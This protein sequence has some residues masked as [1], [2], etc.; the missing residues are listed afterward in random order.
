VDVKRH[1][2]IT[3]LPGVGKTTMIRDIAD[4]LPGKKSGFF[5]RE[6]RSGGRRTG[7]IIETLDG[8]EAILAR[9]TS[10]GAH[11]V[12]A[13]QV[14]VENLERLALPAIQAKA[15]IIIIDEIG[16]MECLSEKF[17]RAVLNI[18]DGDAR[19]VAT[20]AKKGVGFIKEVKNR[21][22][23]SLFEVTPKNRD[24]VA[25]MLRRRLLDSHRKA[26]K[27]DPNDTR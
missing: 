14:F 19:V 27:D 15:D 13:Y 10:A 23:V 21:P 17:K 12:G 2:L 9:K 7:F 4:A 8:G 11:R 25:A 22:D 3:G 16:K 6:E 18:L 1:I 5:T 26:T 24:P 20:V